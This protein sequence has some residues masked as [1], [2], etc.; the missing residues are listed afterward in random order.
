MF[1]AKELAT[2]KGIT[3]KAAEEILQ[4]IREADKAVMERP[5]ID[6]NNVTREQLLH[7]NR[8]YNRAFKA[9]KCLDL[10]QEKLV[11]PQKK[12]LKMIERDCMICE[13]TFTDNGDNDICDSCKDN[14][15]MAIELSSGKSNSQIINF[16][17]D[18]L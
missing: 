17:I 18:K 9:R 8:K 10:H 1:T 13:E 14:M 2:H 6:L 12:G 16:T 4:E 15:K 7:H 11:T 3:I 5:A